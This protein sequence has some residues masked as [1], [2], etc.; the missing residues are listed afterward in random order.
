MIYMQE[1]PYLLLTVVR[2]ESRDHSADNIHI[3][4]LLVSLR[5]G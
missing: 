2:N 3:H 5:S 4:E 1:V